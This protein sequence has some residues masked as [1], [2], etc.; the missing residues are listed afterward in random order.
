M[1]ERVGNTIHSMT[2]SVRYL[3]VLLTPEGAGTTWAGH[4]R[5][6]GTDGYASAL[7]LRTKWQVLVQYEAKGRRLAP[8]GIC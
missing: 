1:R 8:D 6:P 4:L 5:K 7:I 3:L 2:C